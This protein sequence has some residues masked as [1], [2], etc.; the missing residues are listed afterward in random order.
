M[1]SFCLGGSFDFVSGE[2]KRVP[3]RLT[4]IGLEGVLRP[5][6]S[7]K[8]NIKLIIRRI[9]RGWKGILKYIILLLEEKSNQNL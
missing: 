7:E 1:V 2:K 8:G 3:I 4:K 9:N 6:Y 5:F